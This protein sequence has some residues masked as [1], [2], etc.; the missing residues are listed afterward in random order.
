MA[1]ITFFSNKSRNETSRYFFVIIF[2]IITWILQVS[3]FS[4]PFCFDATPNLMLLGSIYIGLTFGPQAGTLY[5]IT[6]SFLGASILYDH[7]FYFSY[8]LIGFLAGLLI[9]N[10]FSDEYLFFILLSFF[11]TFPLELI[12]SW[13]YGFNNSINTFDRYLL[14]AFNGGILNLVSAPL[15]YSLIKFVTKKF[16]LR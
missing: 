16:K 1:E 3:V 2:S 15:F 11:L 4:K 13:Q 6:S 14:V 5:G 8:P 9:K 10:I 12:N 7:V